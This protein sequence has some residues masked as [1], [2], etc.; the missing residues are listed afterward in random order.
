MVLPQSNEKCD[1]CNSSECYS[2]TSVT[3]YDDWG[4]CLA[5]I[6][7][8]EAE[9]IVK[10]GMSD[11]FMIRARV[12][13]YNHGQ[14]YEFWETVITIGS[15]EQLIYCMKYAPFDNYWHKTLL[16][17]QYVLFFKK[18][19]DNVTDT[20]Q[21]DMI[22]DDFEVC[23]FNIHFKTTRESILDMIFYSDLTNAMSYFIQRYTITPDDFI[24]GKFWKPWPI[25]TTSVLLSKNL[26]SN[27]HISKL[28][29]KSIKKKTCMH[30]YEIL[31]LCI[32]NGIDIHQYAKN[33]TL[34]LN[35]FGL[36]EY[37]NNLLK[38]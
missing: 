22:F 37:V 35:M 13:Q 25:G 12:C 1:R 7:F 36:N 34:K 32:E 11:E 6:N 16:S 30:M 14:N 24:L 4:K 19:F 29:D 31:L 26:I 28:I 18:I 15:L 21:L 5:F 10:T 38:E 3:S 27:G 8:E 20:S 17:R 23:G 9:N 2:Y 33:I